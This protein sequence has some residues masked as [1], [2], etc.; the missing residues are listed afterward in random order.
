ML[1]LLRRA[2]IVLT[3]VVGSLALAPQALAAS[4]ISG[5][6]LD[7][8][9]AAVAGSA[10]LYRVGENSGGGNYLVDG[11]FTVNASVAG[12]YQVY[13]RADSMDGYG[14]WYV[15]G[16][17]AGTTNRAD[18]TVI[19]V[20]GA[21]PVTLQ[22]MQFP[23]IATLAGTVTN[24]DGDPMAGV[25][26]LRSRGGV[27]SWATTDANGHYS[28][29]YVQ[30]GVTSIAVNATGGWAG[31][32]QNVTVDGS[33]D[34]TVDLVMQS[35]AAIDG[36]VTDADTG[37]PIPGLRVSAYQ[38]IGTAVSYQNGTRTDAA[39]HYVIDGL[40]P[41]ETVVQ[42]VDDFGGY[43]TVYNGGALLPTSGPGLTTTAGATLTHDEA[44]TQK[45]D[46][47]ADMALSGTVT[48]SGSTDPLVGVEVRAWDAD[49]QEVGS[50]LTDWS[51]RWGIDLPAGAYTVSTRSGSTLLGVDT[52]TP[53]QPVF[54]PDAWQGADGTVIT[55]T[56]DADTH[57]GLDFALTRSAVLTLD[58]RGPGDTTAL[59]A[60]YRV[61]SVG[62]ITAYDEPAV[63]G[64]GNVIE[65]LLRPGTWTL[66]LS[67]QRSGGGA[68]LLPQW[69]G[70]S[71]ATS[72]AATPVTVAAGDEIDGGTITLPAKLAP[73][74]A[75][76]VKGKAKV[77]KKLK[78]T[79][80][81][82]NLMTGTT[83]TFTW[84]RGSK[85]VGHASSHTVATADRGKKLKVKVT[86]TNGAFS[87][88]KTRMVKIA[89]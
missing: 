62:G 23:A 73:T 67:G 58:V 61:T 84:L 69:L 15:E 10:Y 76:T 65:V 51:G 60:G 8:D 46:T 55:V 13:V 3:L 44:L 34:F 83:F 87:A 17:A 41:G 86:A 38:R 20:D 52:G 31:A 9:G 68:A 75:P 70:G 24:A 50:D 81:T 35:P 56:D 25:T 89:G 26:V 4:A 57:P 64:T 71:G 59:D 78:A 32:R 88:T 48:A 37:K 36:T 27:G 29:G 2:L 28:F 21:T 22:Q 6:V 1:S 11:N 45:P 72:G 80:G 12:D 33:S 39:G 7:P 79:K 19:A 16:D 63:S 54:Y 66:R 82:W 40:T 18:A 43:A 42:Y 47:T 85:V 14:R 77:G 74:K 30:P 49:G 53:W 5:R